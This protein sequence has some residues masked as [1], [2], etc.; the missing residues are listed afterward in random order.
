MPPGDAH[1]LAL[2]LR[3]VRETAFG[4]LRPHIAD[5]FT[6]EKMAQTTLDLYQSLLSR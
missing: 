5:T 4:P 1:A 2:A 3:R 6:A